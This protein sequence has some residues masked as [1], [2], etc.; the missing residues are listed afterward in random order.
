ML[1][2]QH[3][4]LSQDSCITCTSA[5]DILTSNLP[6]HG[7]LSCGV[8]HLPT[9][10][11]GT[12]TLEPRWPSNPHLLSRPT[13]SSYFNDI[14]ALT[15]AC[16]VT[17]ISS[18]CYLLFQ[19]YSASTSL[20]RI[21]GLYEPYIIEDYGGIEFTYRVDLASDILHQEEGLCRKSVRVWRFRLWLRSS[22][23][24]RNHLDYLLLGPGHQWR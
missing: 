7:D 12:S 24:S 20:T 18:R 23:L 3:S 5:P 1:H 2:T 17:H 19:S 9:R 11:F 21:P 4:F 10:S 22:H 14:K 6:D 15:T 16:S 13:R 8:S